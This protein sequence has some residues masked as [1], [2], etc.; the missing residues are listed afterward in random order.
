MPVGHVTLDGIE[1]RMKGNGLPTQVLANQMAPKIGSGEGEY[2][3]LDTWSAWI[4]DNWQDGVGKMNPY[5]NDGVLF[6]TA[7]TRVPEQ[8]ILQPLFSWTDRRTVNNT[9][10]DNRYTPNNVTDYITVGG[11]GVNDNQRLAMR[12]RTPAS[13][14]PFIPMSAI[15][16]ERKAVSVTVEIYAE[17]GGNPSGSALDTRTVDYPNVGQGFFWEGAGHT[18]SALSTN[19][20][21]WLVIRPTTQTDTFRVAVGTGG[22]DTLAKRWNG[23][24][25]SNVLS[26]KYP[27]FSIGLH[28]FNTPNNAVITRFKNK[29]RVLADNVIYTYNTANGAWDTTATITFSVFHFNTITSAVEF[30]DFMW[31]GVLEQEMPPETFTPVG[32]LRMNSAGT[33]SSAGF[34]AD[35]LAKHG[36]FL[37]RSHNNMVYYSNDGSTWSG[38]HIICA[39]DERIKSMAGIGQVMYFFT[40]WGIYSLQPGNFT[41]PIAPWGSR[42]HEN[43]IACVAHQGAIFVISNGRIY[44]FSEDGSLMDVWLGQDINSVAGFG[45]KPTALASVNNWLFCL[46]T[47]TSNVTT[48]SRLAVLWV[49]TG[50]GWHTVATLPSTIS[51]NP[52]FDPTDT[53]RNPARLYYDRETGRLWVTS[54]NGIVYGVPIQ[55]YTLNPYF[56]PAY[57]YGHNSF[58]EWDWF[59]GP[60][61]EAPKD[62]ESVTLTG[63]FAAGQSVEVYWKE[64]ETGAWELLGTITADGQ[65]LRWPYDDRPAT[66]KIKLGVLLKTNDA[67]KTPRVRS[68]RV[69]YHTMTRDWFRWTLP[70]DVSGAAIKQELLDGTRRTETAA[71]LKAALDATVK[72]TNPV[73]YRDVDGT[74]YE[75]KITDASFNYT[76]VDYNRTGGVKEWE[77]VYTITIEQVTQGTYTPP[78]PP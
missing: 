39:P 27:V 56:D 70:V 42:H 25:W 29:L 37:W 16:M 62:W 66:K 7:D 55:D 64:T 49:W 59:Y 3:N 11:N 45:F 65:E 48:G 50:T 31:I 26:G 33:V 73:I 74:Y 8:M 5:R 14:I 61:R 57:R 69:K 44:R 4:Q 24:A 76:K 43:G 6:S 58:V 68:I 15:L 12:I 71:Q 20:N 22:F 9:Y 72:K 2:S 17:S 30:G 19:T 78:P 63:E 60:I 34:F 75:V 47:G 21:Y 10:N 52:F 18:G 32:A 23:S 41:V 36:G 1:L 67:T 54:W 77:G 46:T 51:V 28:G 53:Q 38:P 40:E 13:G 35:L